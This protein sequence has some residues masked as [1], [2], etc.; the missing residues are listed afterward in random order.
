MNEIDEKI[1]KIMM[2]YP[3]DEFAYK[4]SPHMNTHER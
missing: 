2:E 3:I 4:Y 1:K